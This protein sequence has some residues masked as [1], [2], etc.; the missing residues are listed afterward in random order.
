VVPSEGGGSGAF[1]VL[2]IFTVLIL[3]YG[4]KRSKG[5]L[6]IIEEGDPTHFSL[7]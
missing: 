2:S 1:T 4:K 3:E 6:L 7:M 5:Y